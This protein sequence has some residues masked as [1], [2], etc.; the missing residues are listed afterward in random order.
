VTP[1]RTRPF[2]VEARWYCQRTVPVIM[3]TSTVAACHWQRALAGAAPRQR[4]QTT[5]PLGWPLAASLARPSARSVAGYC[6]LAPP[7]RARRGDRDSDSL[8]P[9]LSGPPA[10]SE[11]ENT[12]SHR[13]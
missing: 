12:R 8:S 10:E 13:R 1:S 6:S 11:P 2:R 9:S 7:G 5:R 4:P 3:A